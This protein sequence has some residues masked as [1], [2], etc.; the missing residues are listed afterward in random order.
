MGDMPT[1]VV[2]IP[3]SRPVKSEEGRATL[4]SATVRMCV[5]EAR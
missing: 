3:M 2:S 1:R 5:V 4:H